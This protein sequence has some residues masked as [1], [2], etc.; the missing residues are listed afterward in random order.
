MAETVAPGMDPSRSALEWGTSATS[1]TPPSS[2][3]R[4]SGPSS[5]HETMTPANRFCAEEA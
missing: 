2:V 1:F 4:T 5:R 3:M